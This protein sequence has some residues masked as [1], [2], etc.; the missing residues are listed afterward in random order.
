[1]RTLLF[2]S[3]LFVVAAGA[4][5][6][7]RANAAG[8]SPELVSRGAYLV[9]PAGQCADCHRENLAGGPNL[10]PGP[11]NVPWAQKVPSLRGLTMFRTDAAAIAFLQ[12]GTLDNGK[13][14][15]QP[16]PAYRFNRPDATAI[17]AYLRSLK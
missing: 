12:T 7:S 5:V 3:G 14:A 8:S 4:F 6:G 13:T 11:G 16:M 17:V 2:A 15:R 9:G 10:I 1:M